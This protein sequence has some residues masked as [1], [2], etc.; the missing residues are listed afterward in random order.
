[1]AASTV[2]EFVQPVQTERLSAVRNPELNW[3]LQIGVV[4]ELKAPL[5]SEELEFL[6]GELRLARA[7]NDAEQQWVVQNEIMEVL[8]EKGLAAERL[9]PE[10]IGLI[11]NPAISEVTRDYAVQH[12]AQWLFPVMAG[13]PQ[14]SDAQRR[15]D[16][17]TVLIAAASDPAFNQG[18]IQGTA[19]NALMDISTKLPPEEADRLW[20]QLEPVVTAEVKAPNQKDIARKSAVIRAAGARKAQ[21]CYEEIRRFATDE[22][23][24]P[25]L[26]ISAIA[27][28]GRYGHEQDW[29]ILTKLS[30]SNGPLQPAALTALRKFPASSR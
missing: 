4:A 12:L 1:V 23:E 17:L 7:G 27:S 25:A 5:A 26:R 30:R 18:T 3:R 11:R 6:F 2:P 21:G 15:A 22:S 29:E 13:V 16:G 20:S 19:L 10:L 9:T 28:L 8:R 24:H 14:E